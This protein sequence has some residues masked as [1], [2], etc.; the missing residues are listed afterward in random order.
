MVFLFIY[1]CLKF[2]VGVR[3]SKSGYESL[4][5]A[6]TVASQ[7]FNLIQQ[8]EVTIQALDKAFPKPILSLVSSLLSGIF[9]C[10]SSSAF[11]H[12]SFVLITTSLLHLFGIME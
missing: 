7:K 11:S 4:V 3:N 1:L 6:A 5:E 10:S 9:I 12:V 2:F 8:R